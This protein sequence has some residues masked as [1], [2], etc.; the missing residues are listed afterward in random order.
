MPTQVPSTRR[1]RTVKKGAVAEE[2]FA[3][4]KAL[5]AHGLTV[6]QIASITGWSSGAT[7]IMHR[8]DT[9][10]DYRNYRVKASTYVKRDAPKP[11]PSVTKAQDK[12]P[13][14]EVTTRSFTDSDNLERIATALER[15]ADAWES[16]PKKTGL[17]R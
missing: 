8:F 4:V 6:K 12:A 1:K 15:L 2:D 3:K 7:Q 14:P 9:F 5:Q 11:A 17:F 10:E 16:S 13:V